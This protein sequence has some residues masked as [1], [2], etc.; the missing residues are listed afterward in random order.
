[1]SWGCRASSVMCWTVLPENVHIILAA[2]WWD[3]TVTNKW[4]AHIVRGKCVITL[5][6]TSRQP[7]IIIWYEWWTL[8]YTDQS[9]CSTVSANGLILFYHIY[10]YVTCWNINKLI[11]TLGPRP[12]SWHLQRTYS[13]ALSRMKDIQFPINLHKIYFLVFNWQKS[14]SGTDNGLVLNIIWIHEGLMSRWIIYVFIT[15][16]TKWSKSFSGK[17]KINTLEANSLLST[18][19]AKSL[20]FYGWERWYFNWIRPWVLIQYSDDNLLV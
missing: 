2:S 14:S 19:G 6:R 15:M 9:W 11:D 10:I 8:G 5:K 3:N 4:L 18:F 16:M 13:N 1:M 20:S 12:P 17:L 7:M